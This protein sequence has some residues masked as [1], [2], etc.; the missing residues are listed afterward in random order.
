[1]NSRLIANAHFTERA[2]KQIGI[3]LGNENVAALI[4]AA[5]QMVTRT[6]I[7]NSQSSCHVTKSAAPHTEGQPEI[8]KFIG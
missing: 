5:H 4:A 1:M 2:D 7:F 3:L 8:L 6:G